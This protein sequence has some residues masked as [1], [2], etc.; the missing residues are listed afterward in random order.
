MDELLKYTRAMLLLQLQSAQVEAERNDTPALKLELLLADAGFAHKD[1]A[2]MLNK[3]QMAVAKAV[4]R[5][6]S[7]RQ[8]NVAEDAMVGASDL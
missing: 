3:S 5:A 1:I 6:R 8:R 7:A 2:T 4:S